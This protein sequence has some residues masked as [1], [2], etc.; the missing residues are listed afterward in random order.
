MGLLKYPL[1]AVYLAV[2][3]FLFNKVYETSDEVIDELFHLKQGLEYCHEN[4]SAVNYSLFTFFYV[5]RPGTFT[6]WYFSINFSGTLKL[7]H[8]P[9]FIYFRRWSL[10]RAATPTHSDWHPWSVRLS[11]FGWSS[12]LKAW[13]CLR[14]ISKRTMMRCSRRL[15][16]LPC[17]R[18]TSSLTFTT[19]TSLQSQ[20]SCSCCASRCC[21]VTSCRRCQVLR[22]FSCDKRTSSG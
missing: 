6:F 11:T 15:L 1:L 17:R 2:S 20:W 12:R 8:F 18:C 4:F 7:Q 10:L 19:P 3:L 16:L 9:D 13:C 5:R 22:A 21:N 14:L